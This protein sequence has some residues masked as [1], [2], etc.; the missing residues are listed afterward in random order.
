[1]E[2]GHIEHS[3]PDGGTVEMR[4]GDTIAIPLV[5]AH[6]ARNIGSDD[7]VLI[8][9]FDDAWRKTIRE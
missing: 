9:S 2:S 7:A 1:M 4:A 3:L 5:V 8:V 6:H